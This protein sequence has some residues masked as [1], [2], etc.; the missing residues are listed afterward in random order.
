MKV[1]EITQ[2]GL[3]HLKVAERPEP[4]CDHRGR[5][6]R[7]LLK[8]SPS[9]DENLLGQ[10]ANLGHVAIHSFDDD[11]SRHPVQDLPLALAVWMGVVPEESGSLIVRNLHRIVQ[12]LARHGHH[13]ENVVLGCIG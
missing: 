13:G 9:Y 2:F 11:R 7:I 4:L 8:G 6:L 12:T 1:Y 3:D 5:G 10:I